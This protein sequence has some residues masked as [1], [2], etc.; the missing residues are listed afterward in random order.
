LPKFLMESFAP[1]PRVSLAALREDAVLVGALLL[2][3]S[4]AD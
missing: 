3:A 1:G 2:A 4:K